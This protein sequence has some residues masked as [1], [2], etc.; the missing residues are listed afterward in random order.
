MIV[1]K[2]LNEYGTPVSEI[3]CDDCG[4]YVTVCPAVPPEK[5]DQWGSCLTPECPSYD[6]TRDADI[7][8]D[9]AMEH[10]LIEREA[11]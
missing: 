4:K 3:V 8:F 9:A 2:T 6:I 11:S 7:W 10:G 5:H 1:G